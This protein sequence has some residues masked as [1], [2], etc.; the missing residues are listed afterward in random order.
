MSVI[1]YSVIFFALA[2]F[3][4][5]NRFEAIHSSLLI[6]FSKYLFHIRLIH[7]SGIFKI[8]SCPYRI[9]GGNFQNFRTFLARINVVADSYRENTSK[10]N[11]YYSQN[12]YFEM[13]FFRRWC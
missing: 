9:L 10:E 11:C 8:L 4:S 6:V 3:I 7:F 1:N 2:V 5:L 13:L 12:Y